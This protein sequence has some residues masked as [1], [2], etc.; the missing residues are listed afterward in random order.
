[1]Y[2]IFDSIHVP[3]KLFYVHFMFLCSVT[4]VLCPCFKYFTSGS[5][6]TKKTGQKQRKTEKNDKNALVATSMAPDMV[7]AMT[8]Q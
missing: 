4:L 2:H 7:L 5:Y 8:R 1:M 6:Y 3:L